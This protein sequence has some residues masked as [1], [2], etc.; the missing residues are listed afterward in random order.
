MVGA[1]CGA[2]FM[3]L[4]GTA[5]LRWK[6]VHQVSGSLDV[7]NTDP[8]SAEDE[9]IYDACLITRN[10]NKVACD[11]FMRMVRRYRRGRDMKELAQA[12][13]TAGFSKCEIV[14]W[15]YANGFVGSQ[16]SEAVGMSMNDLSK[17]RPNMRNTRRLLNSLSRTVMA[18]ISHSARFI[19]YKH[20]MPAMWMG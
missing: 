4:A 16:M 14:K 9:N 15:G 7:S 6:P 2:V 13:L 3:A 10:G 18:E 5:W 20:F 19:T 1:L 11:A 8:V 12:A 17:C